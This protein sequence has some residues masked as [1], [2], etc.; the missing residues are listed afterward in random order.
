LVL[1]HLAVEAHEPGRYAAVNNPNSNAGRALLSRTASSSSSS[2]SSTSTTST[3]A[4]ASSQKRGRAVVSD[5]SSDTDDEEEIEECFRKEPEEEEQEEQEEEEPQQE[6]EAA[7]QIEQLLEEDDQTGLAVSPLD[8]IDPVVIAEAAPDFVPTYLAYTANPPDKEAMKKQAK[9]NVTVTRGTRPKPLTHLEARCAIVRG[10]LGLPD[11]YVFK[12]RGVGRPKKLSAAER[13][14]GGA[15]GKSRLGSPDSKRRKTDSAAKAYSRDTSGAVDGMET[16]QYP[17]MRLTHGGGLPI[18]R[19]KNE[20]LKL[21]RPRDVLKYKS[22]DVKY[23]GHRCQI[24]TAVGPKSNGHFR[25]RKTTPPRAKLFCTSTHCPTNFCSAACF[26]WWHVGSE[27][28][29]GDE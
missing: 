7:D 11:P 21:H 9:K 6:G 19:L 28:P 10:L 26:N 24:C 23:E 15:A 2:S 12:R 4:P 22:K 13:G 5:F 8:E 14:R 17:N 27:Y 25:N 3:A 16:H 1:C 18:E 20:S 29:E